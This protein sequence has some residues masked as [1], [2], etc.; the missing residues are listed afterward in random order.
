MLNT[1]NMIT[2]NLHDDQCIHKVASS[3]KSVGK[4]LIKPMTTAARSD[5]E[6]WEMQR[7]RKSEMQ[8]YRK[9]VMQRQLQRGSEMKRKEGECMTTRLKNLAVSLVQRRLFSCKGPTCISHCPTALQNRSTLLQSGIFEHS[10]HSTHLKGIAIMY[11][12]VYNI[13]GTQVA[14]LT[15][16]WGSSFLN[17]F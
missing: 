9:E 4:S 8:R 6:R 12:V 11:N 17:E 14:P 15:P 5:R 7:C 1:K 16:T 13:T 10:S 3:C 2:I